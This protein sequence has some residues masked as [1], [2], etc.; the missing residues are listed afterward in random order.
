MHT[1]EREWSGSRQPATAWYVRHVSLPLLQSWTDGAGTF[2]TSAYHSS[3]SHSSSTCRHCVY[4][5]NG[6]QASQRPT[7]CLRLLNARLL[8]SSDRSRL[9]PESDT[10]CSECAHPSDGYQKRGLLACSTLPEVENGVCACAETMGK[11]LCSRNSWAC[12][13]PVPAV[14]STSRRNKAGE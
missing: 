14:T 13:L 3:V 2:R 9:H 1:R 7:S 5:P 12:R 11:Y 4:R 8:H 10:I 6:V